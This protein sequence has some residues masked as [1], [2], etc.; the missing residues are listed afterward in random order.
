MSY[1]KVTLANFDN[2]RCTDGKKEF[3]YAKEY[4]NMPTDKRRQLAAN[5][6]SNNGKCWWVYKWVYNN[7]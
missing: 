7:F 3:I 6:A 4:R 1:E 5:I 2:H